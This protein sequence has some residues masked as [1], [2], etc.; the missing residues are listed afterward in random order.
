MGFLHFACEI[1]H[2][3]TSLPIASSSAA[4][5]ALGESFSCMR[6]CDGAAGDQTAFSKQKASK[7]RINKRCI[8]LPVFYF[9]CVTEDV[10][11]PQRRCRHCHPLSVHSKS[12][13]LAAVFSWNSVPAAA[14][15]SSRSKRSAAAGYTCI[16]VVIIASSFTTVRLKIFSTI[17]SKTHD[18]GSDEPEGP[19]PP[20]EGEEGEGDD[21][22]R[23]QATKD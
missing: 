19:G 12:V 1:L 22:E 10:Q 5:R 16:F 18:G 11:F 4:C 6:S 9:V 23:D 15:T 21:G 7:G 13:L 2:W 3:H 14:V 8:A 17:Y 20:E